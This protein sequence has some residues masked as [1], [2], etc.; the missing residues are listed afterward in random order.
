MSLAVR[1]KGNPADTASAI[2]D[3]IHQ[4][5]AA[6]PVSDMMTMDD[7]LYDSVSSQ[8]F[9]MLLLAVFAGLALVLAGVGIYSVLAYGVRR[10][11][12]EI[13]IRMALGAQVRDVVG[14][15]LID[16]LKPTA[17]GLALGLLGASMLGRVMANLVFGVRTSDPL[18]FAAVS[19][20]LGLVAL[21]ASV[22]PAYRASRVDPVIALR[23][24]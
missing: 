10:R 13:G 20:L 16:G 14:M 22:I 5:N 24:E 18:T 17:F 15:V 8:R 19:L 6:Q 2:I 1:T 12:R 7:L 23:D 21:L 11:A 3:A 9:N 4:V